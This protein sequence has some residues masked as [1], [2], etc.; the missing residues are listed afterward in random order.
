MFS[1]KYM[2][3]KKKIVKRIIEIEEIFRCHWVRFHFSYE[4]LY[5]PS[6][7]EIWINTPFLKKFTD[8]SIFEYYKIHLFIQDLLNN[9]LRTRDL[10]FSV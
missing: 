6:R 2:Q 3:T 8:Y 9:V 10:N 4:A 1:A 5:L 7:R